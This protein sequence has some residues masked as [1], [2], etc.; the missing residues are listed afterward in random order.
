VDSGLIDNKGYNLV[1]FDK[2]TRAETNFPH[3]NYLELPVQ[4]NYVVQYMCGTE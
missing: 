1:N 3:S 4:Y 2:R